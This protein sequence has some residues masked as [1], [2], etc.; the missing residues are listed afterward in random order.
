LV[1]FGKSSFSL[2]RYRKEIS[3]RWPVAWRFRQN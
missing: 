1:G 2:V 3:T